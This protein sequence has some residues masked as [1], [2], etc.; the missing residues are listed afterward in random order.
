MKRP[1]TDLALSP[2]ESTPAKVRSLRRR[3]PRLI[4]T[5]G[6]KGLIATFRDAVRSGTVGHPWTRE[7]YFHGVLC[8][9]LK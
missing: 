7:A 1:P 2:V 9:F 8:F 4:N 3:V 5:G 6:G